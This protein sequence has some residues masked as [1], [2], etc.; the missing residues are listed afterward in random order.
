MLDNFDVN[1]KVVLD[2]YEISKTDIIILPGVGSFDYAARKLKDN[3]W[4]TAIREYAEND[5]F[6]LGICLGMQIICDSSEEGFSEGIGIIPG[7]FKKFNPEKYKIKSPHM[8]WNYVDFIK[9]SRCKS[10]TFS[11]Q[12]YYFVHSY[13]YTHEN[14]KF[15]EGKSNYGLT[16]ASCIRYR[17]VTGVQ[18]HPEKSHKYGLDF[19]K[20]YFLNYKNAHKS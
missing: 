18:F 3:G 10:N 19:F 20:N 16:F 7:K 5:G 1:H 13:Y 12:K 8:G 11:K 2:P 17:N 4:Y 6:L 14:D 9:D 15:I